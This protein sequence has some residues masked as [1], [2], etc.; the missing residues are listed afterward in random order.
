MIYPQIASL[1][2]RGN[3]GRGLFSPAVG[4]GRLARVGQ[5]LKESF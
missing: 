1:E 2:S 5:W 3:A 4:G